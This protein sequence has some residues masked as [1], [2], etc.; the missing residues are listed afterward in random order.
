MPRRRSALFTGGH[1]VELMAPP[2][3]LFRLSISRGGGRI[4]PPVSQANHLMPL[5]AFLYRPRRETAS[6][7]VVVQRAVYRVEVRRHRQARRYTLRIHPATRAVVLTMPPRGSLGEARAFAQQHGGWIAARLNRLPQPA[8]FADGMIVPLR[9]LDHRIVH[10]PAARGV[11][12]TEL[13][14]DGGPLLCAAGAAAHL[15]RRVTDF[16]KREAARDLGVAS[17]RHAAALGVTF[18]R[19][20]IRDQ[21]SRWGSCSSTGVLS[22]S[23]RLIL[24]PPFVLDYLAAHEVAH[25]VELNHSPRFWRTLDGICPDTDRAKAWLDHHGAGLHRYGLT[26]R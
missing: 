26:E 3:R 10:R 6:I 4:L 17:R 8:A 22:F 12:W 21:V 16:L 14:A 7:D 11:A 5:R 13:A 2:P 20:S 15:N 19:I 1:R 9:G 23:W 25:L 18:K 24:A